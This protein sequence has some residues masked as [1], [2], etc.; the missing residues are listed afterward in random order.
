MANGYYNE[1]V[2]LLTAHGYR[3]I[4]NAKGAHEKWRHTETGRIQIVPWPI[5]SRHTANGI[6][7]DIG[8]GKKF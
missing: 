2:A 8:A 3:R 6:C 5:K 1:V 7:K 4:G